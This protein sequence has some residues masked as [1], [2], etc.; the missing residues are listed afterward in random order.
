MPMINFS[1]PLSVFIALLLFVL[2][3]WFSKQSKR[4][5]LTGIMLFFFIAMLIGHST[6]FAIEGLESPNTTSVIYS[7]IYDLVFILL[8]FISY[9]WMD[10]IEAKAKKKRSI[11]NSLKWFW[12]KV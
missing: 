4:S 10:E 6:Q 1:D 2:I 5:V 9:L 12:S 7:I 11:D 3:L 8:S